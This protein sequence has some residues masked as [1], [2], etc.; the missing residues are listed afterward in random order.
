ML[1][2][3]APEGSRRDHGRRDRGFERTNRACR[4]SR[5]E[6]PPLPGCRSP[7]PAW[8][9][10]SPPPRPVTTNRRSPSPT[11][12]ST[13]P[14]WRSPRTTPSSPGPA[15]IS[16]SFAGR[17]GVPWMI[18]PAPDRGP[19]CPGGCSASP[20]RSP[21][22]PMATAPA[23]LRSPSDLASAKLRDRVCSRTGPRRDRKGGPRSGPG[24]FVLGLHGVRVARHP[25]GRSAGAPSR[26]AEG[27]PD[28][29]C[30]PSD[31]RGRGRRA[32]PT[33]FA[34]RRH[35]DQRQARGSGRATV[36]ALIDVTIRAELGSITRVRATCLTSFRC[37]T[38]GS[39]GSGENRLALNNVRFSL[40]AH[41]LLL[42]E[43]HLSVP[44]SE[45]VAA[46]GRGGSPRVN[47]WRSAT[48]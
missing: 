41:R 26:D 34:T 21:A 16:P 32:P 47:R 43:A 25:A 22:S 1:C 48:A 27:A 45:A 12:S 15:R 18:P 40:V 31:V 6:S 9:W 3:R 17:P 46:L 33:R 30:A 44:G 24:A 28:P 5:R 38:R 2:G 36:G 8:S 11:R 14:G 39:N 7:I 23:P 20:I 10:P 19:G 35:R 37:L 4:P 13:R 42:R 29:P